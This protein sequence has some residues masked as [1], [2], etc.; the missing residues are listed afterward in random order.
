MNSQQFFKRAYLGK[1]R[2]QRKTDC[3]GFEAEGTEKAAF[4]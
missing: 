3:E 1:S 4:S 2:V